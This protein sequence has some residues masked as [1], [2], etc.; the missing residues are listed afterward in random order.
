MK[1]KL[2]ALSILLLGSLAVAGEP[3][4]T[5]ASTK[6]D[7]DSV[8]KHQE[9]SQE[10]KAGSTREGADNTSINKRDSQSTEPTADQQKNNQSDVDLT[11]KIRRSIVSDKS[12]S[13]N[14]HNVKII[15][16]NGVVTLKGPVHSEAE[17]STIEQ[18]ASSIAGQSKV[19]N[20]I[21][22]KP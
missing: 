12:L 17:K 18:R 22:V 10:V 16:Q 4:Q 21:D 2:S 14:A 5:G 8:Q 19:K 7:G 3:G 11:A 15:A 13:T 6:T 9:T 1:T 20:E